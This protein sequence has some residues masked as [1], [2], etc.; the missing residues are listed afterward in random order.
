MIMYS[1][2][3]FFSL[4]ISFSGLQ[5]HAMMPV[6]P[7]L[8]AQSQCLVPDFSNNQTTWDTDSI[9]TDIAAEE[10]FDETSLGQAIQT[11]D[12]Q[13]FQ[14]EFE[15]RGW[16]RLFR[17][18]FEP[19]DNYKAARAWRS[20][21]FAVTFPK[22]HTDGIARSMAQELMNISK[23]CS[24]PDVW[25][26]C[27]EHFSKDVIA[28]A[29]KNGHDEVKDQM[30]SLNDEYYKVAD[31]LKQS[32]QQP[33]RYRS[34]LDGDEKK[35]YQS[36][37]QQVADKFED[38]DLIINSINL[39][40]WSVLRCDDQ[41]KTLLMRAIDGGARIDIIEYIIK[42][43]IE[44]GLDGETAINFA[45][46]SG[47]TALY[48]Y[49][50]NALFKQFSSRGFLLSLN[51]SQ[52][53]IKKALV[54]STMPELD[55]SLI[56]KLQEAGPLTFPKPKISSNKERLAPDYRFAQGTDENFIYK[57]IETLIRL[58][59]S[60]NDA[61]VIQAIEQNEWVAKIR[62]NV[63]GGW[64]LLMTA[65]FV[66]RPTLLPC[67]INTGTKLGLNGTVAVN[68]KNKWNDTALTFAASQHNY[69]SVEYLLTLNPSQESIQKA[70]SFTENYQERELLISKLD[71]ER[72]EQA[73]AQE[74]A[75]Q[76]RLQQ[77][78]SRRQEEIRKMLQQD[79]PFE[80]PQQQVFPAPKPGCPDFRPGAFW[81]QILGLPSTAS[82]KD[83]N[84]KFHALAKIYHPD[85]F[86]NN[87]EIWAGYGIKTKK[88]AGAA[89][90]KIIDARGEAYK[91]IKGL[92]DK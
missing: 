84:K 39:Q 75:K 18:I 86:E 65:A 36:L 90:R 81:Y 73:R 25:E 78:Q 64:T 11:G 63:G 35:I 57:Y 49:A 69:E 70:L 23:N 4:L 38:A 51:P 85:R 29:A 43:G 2:K 15:G 22:D 46:K 55:A 27:M 41:G 16:Q 8:P 33:I 83:V 1:K 80:A 13:R 19:S 24:K 3:I 10:E 66:P 6:P 7:Q 17:A 21:A 14:R 82:A 72:Q 45:D 20:L 76:E 28:N 77:E 74:R 56:K 31:T 62:D 48:Y 42:T 12:I 50:A 68:F 92:Y 54:V 91:S 53:N 60:F 79:H 58:P 89:F 88:K 26:A 59:I 87:K 30:Q 47:N 5:L 34:L 61:K 9:C 32:T 40:K 37:E 71:P 52:E 67:I 44:F